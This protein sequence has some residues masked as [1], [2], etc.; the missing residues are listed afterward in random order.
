[1][2]RRVLHDDQWEKIEDLLSGK[3]GDPG[4]TA[5]HIPPRSNRNRLR[6]GDGRHK[7]RLL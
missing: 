6:A 4:A 2:T 1:M 3:V 7:D 5:V